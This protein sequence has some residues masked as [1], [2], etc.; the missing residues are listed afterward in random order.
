[1]DSYDQPTRPWSFAV[2]YGN[3]C[4]L[5]EHIVETIIKLA[6]LVLTSLEAKQLKRSL[7]MPS[8]AG[9]TWRRR[10]PAGMCRS[11]LSIDVTLMKTEK[12]GA[13]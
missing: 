12:R 13:S 1:V 5:D 8:V 2:K 11:K 4:R 6:A 3:L 7:S 10:E 9:D